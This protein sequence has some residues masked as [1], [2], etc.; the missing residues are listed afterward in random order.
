MADENDGDYDKQNISVVICDRFRSDRN[1][2]EVEK[3]TATGTILQ[4][5]GVKYQTREQI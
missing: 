3:K 1:T 4:R 5:L 2:F